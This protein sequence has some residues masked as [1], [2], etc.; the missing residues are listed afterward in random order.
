MSRRL[1][2]LCLYVEWIIE[3][4]INARSWTRTNNIEVN[5]LIL[6]IAVRI[7]IKIRCLM[8]VLCQLSYPGIC[9]EKLESFGIE[10]KVKTCHVF[11]IN[12]VA[13][14]DPHPFRTNNCP[15]DALILILYCL[16][17]IYVLYIINFVLSIAFLKF[18]FSFLLWRRRGIL[19]SRLAIKRGTV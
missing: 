9:G 7:F 18:L 19:K 17:L 3:F 11:L 2:C 5:S 16:I 6:K 1:C 13:V 12:K 15:P 14:C 4:L 8:R 10:P